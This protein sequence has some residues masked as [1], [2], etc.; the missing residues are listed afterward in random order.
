MSSS[1][2]AQN[3]FSFPDQ[4]CYESESCDHHRVPNRSLVVF[5]TRFLKHAQHLVY[6][7]ESSTQRSEQTVFHRILEIAKLHHQQSI[8]HW[9]SDRIFHLLLFLDQSSTSMCSLQLPC[10]GS[11]S[12]IQTASEPTSNLQVKMSLQKCH[13]FVPTTFVPSNRTPVIIPFIITPSV[14]PIRHN[15]SHRSMNCQWD[16]SVQIP[17]LSSFSLVFRV[18]RT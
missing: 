10:P 18:L 14:V 15:S 17:E 13:T 2:I 3:E 6:L 9:R 7:R 12:P 5:C 1:P 11:S 4:F 8:H 16:T